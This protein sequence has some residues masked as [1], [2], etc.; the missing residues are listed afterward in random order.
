M[1]AEFDFS[2]TD[3]EYY[4]TLVRGVTAK[5]SDLEAQFQPVIAREVE[6]VTPIEKA[7]LCIAVYELTERLDVP[8]QVVINEAVE[9]AKVF[10]ATDAHRFINSALDNLA[11]QVREVEVRHYR[12]QRANRRNDTSKR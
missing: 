11:P 3:M 2:K 12:E 9:L 6:E 1:R 7:I 5:Q 10:G 8:F 4:S